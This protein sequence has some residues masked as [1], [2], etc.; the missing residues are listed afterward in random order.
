MTFIN[1]SNT[2]HFKYM[3][4]FAR[5]TVHPGTYCTQRKHM[6]HE[7][8]NNLI[9]K[10]YS[11]DH[12]QS[13]TNFKVR[14]GY[15]I[16]LFQEDFIQYLDIQTSFISGY[17]L[18]ISWSSKYDLLLAWKVKLAFHVFSNCEKVLFEYLRKKGFTLWYP[19]T[20]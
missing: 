8:Y 17:F 13:D 5:N 9:W 18:H 19:N 12:P 1:G 15:K 11:Q 7:S 2:Q 4:Y 14:L 3:S 16:L 6:I 20:Q 10:G